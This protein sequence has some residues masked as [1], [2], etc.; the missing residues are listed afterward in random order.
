MQHFMVCF[1][2][3][4]CIECDISLR[5]YPSSLQ[6]LDFLSNIFIKNLTE[7]ISIRMLKE[8]FERFGEIVVCKVTSEGGT[9][10]G[11]IQFNKVE[12]AE[13][14]AEKM[15]GKE[16]LGNTISVA[17]EKEKSQ[18]HEERTKEFTNLIVQNL[19]DTHVLSKKS[20]KALS[21]KMEA[22]LSKDL[23][24]LKITKMLLTQ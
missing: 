23:S 7:D 4:E 2:I 14:A 8:Q 5:T 19:P 20:K 21:G 3:I 1:D 18:P 6:N 22:N 9:V 15:N 16:L 11:L 17:V 12:S 24:I 13:E 10:R